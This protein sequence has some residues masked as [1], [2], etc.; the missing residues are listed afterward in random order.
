MSAPDNLLQLIDQAETAKQNLQECIGAKIDA[1][2]AAVS[3]ASAAQSAAS[4]LDQARTAVGN[5]R[6]QLAE[7]I[8]KLYDP[9][10]TDV[11]SS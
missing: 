5:A 9:T 1:D 2:A 10:A 7:L 3:A 4:D 8:A 11:V 6:D